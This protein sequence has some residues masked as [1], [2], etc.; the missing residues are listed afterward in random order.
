MKSLITENEKQRIRLMHIN[1][2]HKLLKEQTQFD[3]LLEIPPTTDATAATAAT[4]ATS[5]PADV[6]KT[7]TPEAK[8]FHDWMDANHV[9]WNK[10]D[11]KKDW[12][13][14]KGSK[15]YGIVGDRTKAAWAKFKDEYT[16]TLVK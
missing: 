2:K 4:T 12:N 13:K 3:D 1:Q 6:P 14:T 5:T 10:E 8:A 7:N 9:K 11:P 16:K 15:A